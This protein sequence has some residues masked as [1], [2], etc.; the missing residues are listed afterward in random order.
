MGKLPFY[1]I[2][3]IAFGWIIKSLSKT[4]KILKETKQAYKIKLFNN[5]YYAVVIIFVI[6]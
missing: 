3:G 4:L 1:T 5:F 2:N 6:L